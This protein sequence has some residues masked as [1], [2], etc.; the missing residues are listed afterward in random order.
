MYLGKHAHASYAVEGV[1]PNHSMENEHLICGELQWR[2]PLG[3]AGIHRCGAITG[4]VAMPFLFGLWGCKLMAGWPQAQR[5]PESSDTLLRKSVGRLVGTTF[6]EF[7]RI[8]GSRVTPL[9]VYCHTLLAQS[10]CF[11]GTWTGRTQRTWLFPSED[12]VGAVISGTSATQGITTSAPVD[13]E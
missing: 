10:G 4:L 12:A 6:S 1:L 13:E 5:V 7:I 8:E 2:L 9:G 11:E 3:I